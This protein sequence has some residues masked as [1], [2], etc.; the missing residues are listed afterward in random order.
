MNANRFQTEADTEQREWTLIFEYALTFISKLHEMMYVE[1]E[2]NKGKIWRRIGLV[3]IPKSVKML[4]SN[5][6]IFGPLYRVI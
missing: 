3:R 5:V 6:T 4:N 2:K 1:A